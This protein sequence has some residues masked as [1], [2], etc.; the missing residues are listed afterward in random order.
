MT[1][2]ANFKRADRVGDLI[3][4]EI[5]GI[6][7]KDVRDP[8]LRHITIT[9]VKM[10]DDLRSAKIFFVPLGGDATGSDETI[11]GLRRASGFFR[12]ELGRKLRLRYVPEITFMYDKS[13][14][15]GDRIDRLLAGIQVQENEDDKQD[16]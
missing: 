10:S 11:E 15:Y 13:F 2:S 1:S 6:L 4:S 7:L 14:E 5:S 9:G 3:K 12:K 16:S 8:R